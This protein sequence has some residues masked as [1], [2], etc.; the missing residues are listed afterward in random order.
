VAVGLP[1]ASKYIGSFLY[2]MK[3]NDPAVLTLAVITLLAAILLA[4]FVPAQRASRIDP[5]TALRQE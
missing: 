4:G 3:P 5:I 2:G 1:A